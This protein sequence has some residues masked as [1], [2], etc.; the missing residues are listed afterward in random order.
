MYVM[1]FTYKCYSKKTNYG[2]QT[3]QGS[4]GI[5]KLRIGVPTVAQWK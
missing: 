5:K 3:V 4:R 2:L 1:L